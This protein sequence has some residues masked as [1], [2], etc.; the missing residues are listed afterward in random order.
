VTI[1]DNPAYGSH[2]YALCEALSRTRGPIVELGC[3]KYSTPLIEHIARLTGRYS[4]H[5]D[6]SQEWLDYSVH[7]SRKIL[8]TDWRDTSILREIGRC[9]LVFVDQGADGLA[10]LPWAIEALSVADIVLV[11]DAHI[12][13][14]PHY[15]LRSKLIPC[16]TYHHFDERLHPCSLAVSRV[17]GMLD[18]WPV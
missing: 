6:H 2:V 13:D 11:H 18:H 16:A 10:R 15:Q 3:G 1:D 7:Y 8:V 4:Y 17:L 9:G 5:L 12:E 14:E